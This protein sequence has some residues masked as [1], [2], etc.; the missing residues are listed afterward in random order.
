MKK[1][2]VAINGF[3]RIGRVF[4]K[5]AFTNPNINIVAINDITDSKTLAHLLKYDSVHGK[6]DGE[7]KHDNDHIYVNG[8]EVKIGVAVVQVFKAT[9]YK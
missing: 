4:F 7:I 5:C 3:G 8:K 1:I 6:F 2:N 9:S